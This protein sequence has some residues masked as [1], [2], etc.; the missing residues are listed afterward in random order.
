MSPK[1]LS[2]IPYLEILANTKD[3]KEKPDMNGVLS[4]S[5]TSC[6]PDLIKVVIKFIK[7]DRPRCLFSDLP[8]SSKASKLFQFLDYLCIEKPKCSLDGLNKELK[9]VFSIKGK[10]GVYSEI[11]NRSLARDACVKLCWTGRDLVRPKEQSKLYN[12]V[13]YILSHPGTFYLRLRQ[14][15][16]SWYLE[17]FQITDKQRQ[18][19]QGWMNRFPLDKEFYEDDQSSSGGF[20]DDSYNPGYYSDYD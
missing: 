6:D 3:F 8:P 7:T 10:N 13:E 11:S 15:T 18:L 16:H 1:E 12:M 5:E 14:V 20:S 4:L 17:Y 2:K 9:N 19:L